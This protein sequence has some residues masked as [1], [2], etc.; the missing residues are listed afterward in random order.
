MSI[1][2]YTFALINL[3]LFAISG[4]IYLQTIYQ[5]IKQGISNRSGL[6]IVALLL[7]KYQ[8]V[9]FSFVIFR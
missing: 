4:P 5:I 9:I 2:E 6:F 1:G 8:G 7:S 3:I